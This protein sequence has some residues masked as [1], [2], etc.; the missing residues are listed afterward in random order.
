ME[1]HDDSRVYQVVV[2]DEEQYS[3]WW[4]DREMPAGWRAE[5]TSGTREEC[6][7][8]IDVVWTDMRPASLRRRMEAAQAV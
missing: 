4:E 8:H 3:I 7:A 2:N 1:E 6:L 5:G